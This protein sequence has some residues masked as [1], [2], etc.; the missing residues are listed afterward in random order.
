MCEYKTVRGRIRL[1][2]DGSGSTRM[3][4]ITNGKT[5]QP[6]LFCGE[7]TWRNN[8]NTVWPGFRKPSKFSLSRSSIPLP[9]LTPWSVTAGTPPDRAGLISTVL[10]CYTVA[11]L[12]QTNQRN[13]LERLYNLLFLRTKTR[14]LTEYQP[15]FGLEFEFR[16]KYRPPPNHLC[17]AKYR[18]KHAKMTIQMRA[19]CM[20]FACV[21]DGLDLDITRTN[22][23]ATNWAKHLRETIITNCRN[24]AMSRNH[25]LGIRTKMKAS[26]CNAEKRH[27]GLKIV[28]SQNGVVS[29][30]STT[31]VRV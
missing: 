30:R 18:F 8:C 12:R 1:M 10:N 4:K 27:T 15:R 25:P 13:V 11:R 16:Q 28:S 3:A 24:I 23:T 22:S 7:A 2:T 19:S 14:I 5:K 29:G 21:T 26:S 17:R 31:A 20:Q 6:V 9:W